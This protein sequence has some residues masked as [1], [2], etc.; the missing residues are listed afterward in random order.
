[1]SSSDS[2]VEKIS[3]GQARLR[4]RKNSNMCMMA[5]ISSR[6]KP[7]GESWLRGQVRKAQAS[8]LP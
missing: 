1:M 4:T 7:E 5:V 6:P 2:N 3:R 8:G